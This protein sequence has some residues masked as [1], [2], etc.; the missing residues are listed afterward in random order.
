[1][2][3]DIQ[4]ITVS[5]TELAKLC[6]CSPR[7]IR[8][9]DEEGIIVNAGTVNKKSYVLGDAI[10]AIIAKHDS[11]AK[12]K[13]GNAKEDAERKLKA[14]A[15][16]KESQAEMAEIKLKEIKGQMHRSDDVEAAMTDIVYAF[17]SA[18]LALPGKL[19]MDIIKCKEPNEAS[20]MIREECYKALEDLSN[21][22]YDPEF[23]KKRVIEREGMSEDVDESRNKETQ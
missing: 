14:E 6:G 23:Y 4:K 8:Y 5:S 7:M 11:D 10:K 16:Y 18:M 9:Y 17:R 12:A 1:M 13:K 15:D 22:K 2:T 20:V 19:A 21:Y 3:K